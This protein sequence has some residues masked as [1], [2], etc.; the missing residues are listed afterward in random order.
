[1]KKMGIYQ[2][3]GRQGNRYLWYINR[4]CSIWKKLTRSNLL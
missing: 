2:K 4:R 1:M 3:R